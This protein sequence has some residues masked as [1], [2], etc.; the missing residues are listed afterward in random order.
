VKDA[1]RRDEWAQRELAA[2]RATS[3]AEG[4]NLSPKARTFLADVMRRTFGEG[5]ADLTIPLAGLSRST[6]AELSGHGMI[7]TQREGAE[8]HLELTDPSLWGWNPGK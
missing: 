5:R 3:S 8:L 1:D 7:R 4:H 6:L 2:F